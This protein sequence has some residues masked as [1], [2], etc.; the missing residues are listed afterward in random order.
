MG[1][2]FI[3]NTKNTSREISHANEGEIYSLIASFGHEVNVSYQT[4]P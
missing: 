3:F 1:I 4:S 2:P